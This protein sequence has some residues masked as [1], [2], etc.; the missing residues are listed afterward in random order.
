MSIMKNRLSVDNI[1]Y[2]F[3]IINKISHPEKNNLARKSFKIRKLKTLLSL[4]DA[5]IIDKVS[6]NHL[7]SFHLVGEN[8]EYKQIQSNL[9]TRILDISMNLVNDN[10]NEQTPDK[11]K[12]Q[13]KKESYKSKGEINPIIHHFIFNAKNGLKHQMKRV[14]RSNNLESI[15]KFVYEKNRKLKKVGKLR[16][17]SGE[18]E[19]ENEKELGD[20]G[21]LFIGIFDFVLLISSGFYLLYMPYRLATTKMIINS[22][23]YFIL[24]L[25]DLS[26]IIYLLDLILGFLRWYYNNEFKLVSNLYMIISK[27]L[28]SDFFLD[29]IMAIPFYTILRFQKI[30]KNDNISKYNESYFLLKIFISFKAFKI[31][32]LNRIK[33]NR[34]VYFINQK[35][36]KNYFIERIYQIACFIL[37]ILT[38][39]NL[40]I[41]LHIYMAE[42]SYPNWI[43]SNDLIDSSFLDIYFASFYF[44]IATMTS[45][46]YGDITCISFEETCFQII[47]LSIGLV[48]YSWIISTV[49]DYV[50]NQSRANINYDRDMTKL[51]EIRIAYPNMTFKLY[52]KI[53]QHIRRKLTQNKKYEYN[54]LINSLPYYLQNSIF[55]QIH[56]NEID[57]FTFFK[58]C[59]NSDFIL[60]VLTHF[61]PIFSKQNIV[62]VGEGELFEN[63]FFIKNGRLSLEAIIDLD[64]FEMSIEKYLKYRLEEID[65]I[66]ELSNDEISHEKSRIMNLSFRK[67][68]KIKHKKLLEIINKQLEN[69]EEIPDLNESNIEQEIGQIDF[70]TEIHDLYKGNIKYIPILDLLKNE[71]FGDILMFSNIP[72]PLSLR[73]K[74][75]RVELFILRKKDAFNI[76]KDYP[77]IWYRLNKKSTHNIKSLKSLTLNIIRRYCEMNGINAKDREIL[78][79]KR[80]KLNNCVKFSEDNIKKSFKSVSISKLNS[81]KGRE[82]LNNSIKKIK[83]Y[84]NIL[85]KKNRSVKFPCKK[86]DTLMNEKEII[87]INENE[88]KNK[89]YKN[90]IKESKSL[91]PNRR[92]KTV[93]SSEIP[94]S[95]LSFSLNEKNNNKKINKLST[96]LNKNNLINDYNFDKY[97]K[98][99]EINMDIYKMEKY[100]Q[101]ENYNS[102]NDIFNQELLHGNSINTNKAQKTSNSINPLVITRISELNNN[103][104]INL[105]YNYMKKES[106]I[107]LQIKSSYEN[108]NLISKGKYIKN[109]KFQ[110]IIQKIVKYYA[111]TNFKRKG[112]KYF[113]KLKEL[114]EIVS[115]S[116]NA[117]F[118]SENN[119]ISDKKNIIKGKNKNKLLKNK[120]SLTNNFEESKSKSNIEKNQSIS[121]LNNKFIYQKSKEFIFSLSKGKVGFESG[122]G[123]SV[124][125][126]KK[127]NLIDI[128]RNQEI[129]SESND[130]N[131][132]VEPLD[133]NNIKNKFTQS[134][135]IIE[136]NGKNSNLKGIVKK[137][138]SVEKIFSNNI[139]KKKNENSIHELNLNYVNNFCFIY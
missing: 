17:S 13:Q 98:I 36:S 1:K 118:K 120:S 33:N 68:K 128:N 3:N 23:E 25:I 133:K 7:S 40:I 127:L 90:F 48:A 84:K 16:D 26:E 22:N 15:Q 50:K 9:Q 76:K 35:F 24:A 53:Q 82:S 110:K 83:T 19:S 60:K 92:K 14:K 52:K 28:S 71:Y 139:I 34:V 41:C 64:N 32:K 70:H 72:N 112:N 67:H 31:F 86:S 4:Y 55:L 103:K 115:K 94:S 62:L 97:K 12:I 99:N 75:K 114:K 63:I 2:N 8:D 11:L 137:E 30:D 42:I 102:R 95:S 18:D 122:G 138:K 101:I 124:N 61:I 45:V 85:K 125:N 126:I 44:I 57:H 66:G 96:I 38:L 29:L 129:L 107:S 37:L 135:K 123:K 73:V 58:H 47:L 80:E 54:I 134:F 78:N 79:S 111:K 104:N 49:G 113:N 5:K 105:K 93:E 77:N 20:C 130:F 21:I 131:I 59:D 116:Q 65:Q 100:L 56:K 108:I 117:Y 74:S 89:I 106:N 39:F 81:K 91:S 43:V 46:G 119:E 27:Y 109:N 121:E 132:S 88:Q 51:E 136:D 6:K 10:N 69:I 87:L